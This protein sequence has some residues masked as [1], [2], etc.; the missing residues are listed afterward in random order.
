MLRDNISTMDIN[1]LY[2]DYHDKSGEQENKINNFV[3]NGLIHIIEHY[4]VQWSS[5]FVLT[6]CCRNNHTC[7]FYNVMLEKMF[8]QWQEW[9]LQIVNVIN[10]EQKFKVPGDRQYNMIFTDSYKAFL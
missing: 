6:L 1:A 3:A 2:N 8:A 7:N 10:N 4:F 9:P 5:F